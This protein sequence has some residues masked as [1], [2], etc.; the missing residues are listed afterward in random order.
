MA[1]YIIITSS[2]DTGPDGSQNFAFR[3]PDY[4]NV[5]WGVEN[6]K[7]IEEEMSVSVYITVFRE[8]MEEG[9]IVANQIYTEDAQYE[10]L[11]VAAEEVINSIVDDAINAA[12]E[13][14]RE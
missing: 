9:Q 4:P 14:N 10:E 3:R 11:A 13:L 6:M 7:W 1:E 2:V 5:I 12:K 8:Q